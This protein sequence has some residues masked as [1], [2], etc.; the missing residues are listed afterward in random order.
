MIVT[1]TL[2]KTDVLTD[3]QK[4]EIEHAKTMPITFDEDSPEMTDEMEKS[5]RLAAKT[6]NRYI[7]LKKA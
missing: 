1:A 7:S 4:K 5:F 6:R 2:S 3:A